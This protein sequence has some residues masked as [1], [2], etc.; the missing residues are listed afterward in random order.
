MNI[1]FYNGMVVYI[2]G[3]SDVQPRKID[4]FALYLNSI[5]NLNK[6]NINNWLL[7]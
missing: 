3:K 1:F 7:Y 4:V 6:Q 5:K 2:V